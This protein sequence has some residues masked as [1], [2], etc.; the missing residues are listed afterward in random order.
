MAHSM[1]CSTTG[2]TVPY[3]NSPALPDQFL[4]ATAIPLL[5]SHA[6]VT[7]LYCCLSTSIA[8]GFCNCSYKQF[9][10][11][12]ASFHLYPSSCLTCCY[13]S[14][15]VWHLMGDYLSARLIKTAE[16][17]PQGRYVFAAYPHGISAISGW[18][19]FAT[20]AA[21]FSRLFPGEKQQC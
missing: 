6:I 4:T 2:S 12:C 16:L 9:V 10:V 15:P 17:D 8:Q 18:V 7:V 21:G 14:L 19:C 3:C 1:T 20:E 13:C 5:L 11:T